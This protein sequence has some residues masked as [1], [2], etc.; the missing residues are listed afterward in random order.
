MPHSLLN[1]QDHLPGIGLIPAP[2]QLFGRQPELDDE[3]AREVFGLDLAALFAPEA[4]QGGFVIAHDDPGIRA[5]DEVAAV[6]PQTGAHDFSQTGS[7]G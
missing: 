4:D 7:P 6:F 2:V 5:A 1:I 3:V